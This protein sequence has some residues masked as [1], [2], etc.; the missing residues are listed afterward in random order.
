MPAGALSI[1]HDSVAQKKRDDDDDP[2]L[3]EQDDT[4]AKDKHTYFCPE[5]R[6]RLI[7][8]LL[9]HSILAERYEVTFEIACLFINDLR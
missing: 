1:V 9:R 2:P 7:K 8:A 6:C 3:H 5:V 4:E